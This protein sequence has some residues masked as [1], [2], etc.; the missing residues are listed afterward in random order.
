M[1]FYNTK[2]KNQEELKPRAAGKVGMYVCGPTVYA[3]PHIGNARS[4]V[5]YDLLYR[6]LRTKYEVNYVRNITDVDD[7]INAAAKEN[8]E[9]ISALTSRVT[10]DFH[11][12]MGKL[13][14]L[15][16]TV[17]PRA[18]LHIAEMV[19][20][21]E[22][23]LANGNAYVASDHVLFDVTSDKK[24]GHLSRRSLDEMVAGSRVEVAPYKKN[25]GDF[26]LW[27]PANEGDDAS[28]IFDSPWGKGRPGWHTECVAMS[29]KYLGET[30]D[31]HG[32]GA[33]LTFPHHENE[34][35]QG[36]CANKGSGYANMWMHNGF[37]TV[38]GEKM[39]KSAGNFTTVRELLDKGV[40]GE[41]I[42]WALLSSHYRS[43][44]DWTE[45]LISD[46][47]KTMDGFYRIRANYSDIGKVSSAKTYEFLEDDLNMSKVTAELH[48]YVNLCNNA[49]NS[50]NVRD[51]A[52]HQLIN[53][54]KLMGFLQQ[55]ADEYFGRS[56][57]DSEVEKLIEL[58]KTAK[59]AKDYAQAD[60][61]REQLT[62]MGIVIEDKPGGVTEW[63]KI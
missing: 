59:N 47:K 19:E 42:R 9:P 33:D 2:T 6:V 40:N 63:R 58:R 36:C 3:S 61:I 27:K 38:D 31:I 50:Q 13:G 41:V 8:G 30:F 48:G 23:L 46:A 16:P 51:M 22:K 32:G 10:V 28:S 57:A 34:V 53:D 44:L 20:L 17:E 11:E 49:E 26:V 35:A 7:K 39:S 43:P 4:V 52:A 45:K 21:I 1:R 60:K 25:P 29:T 5:I 14:C 56:G 18:T 55:G 62:D 15:K 37:L 54:L 12:V 24:Y